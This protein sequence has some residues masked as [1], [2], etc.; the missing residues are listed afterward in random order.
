M[1]NTIA[2][3]AEHQKLSKLVLL[4]SLASGKN[5]HIDALKGNIELED[6]V[7]EFKARNGGRN[8]D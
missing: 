3:L 2:V 6:I 4:E 5:C 7:A 1:R 8:E